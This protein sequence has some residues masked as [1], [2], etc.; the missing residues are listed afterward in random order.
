MTRD[1][2]KCQWGNICNSKKI[3]NKDLLIHHID[4]ND[5]NNSS[6]NL[7]TLCRFCHAGFHANNHIEK[8]F[9]D[10]LH[11]RINKICVVCHKEFYIIGSERKTCSDEC[12]KNRFMS[13]EERTEYQKKYH[14]LYY[15]KMKGNKGFIKMLRYRTKKWQKK[16]KKKL[17]DYR[18][19]RYWGNIEESRRIGR[20][21]QRKWYAKHKRK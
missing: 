15:Q 9:Q 19:K 16:N 4:F 5:N 18:K 8:K 1:A 10:N 20:E 2:F 7:I 21:K 11:K 17:V 6:N 12:L 3:T 13:K 14:K